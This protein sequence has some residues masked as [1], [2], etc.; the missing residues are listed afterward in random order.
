VAANRNYKVNMLKKLCITHGEAKQ[1]EI[2]GEQLGA[3]RVVPGCFFPVHGPVL[4]DLRLE[5]RGG[6]GEEREDFDLL[7][8]DLI[9]LTSV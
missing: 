1:Q 9:P 2:S 3:G 5:V 4:G 7:T 8:S 6:R